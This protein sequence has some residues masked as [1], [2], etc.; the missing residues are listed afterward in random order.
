M[1]EY[2]RVSWSVQDVTCKALDMGLKLSDEQAEEW[3][4]KN[5]KHIADRMVERGWDAM[6]TLLGE[7]YPTV[8]CK[9]CEESTDARTAHRHDGGYVCE[10][11]WDERLRATE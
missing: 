10:G 4:R 11:C 1:P 9:F 8:E 6:E 7:D 5:E 3:L 2:A